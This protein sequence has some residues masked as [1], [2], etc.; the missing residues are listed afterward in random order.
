MSPVRAERGLPRFIQPIG[1]MNSA[2]VRLNATSRSI[3][4][5][6]SSLAGCL[7]FFMGSVLATAID[8]TRTEDTVLTRIAFGSCADQH[9]PC[10][11]W[12]TI[13]EYQPGLLLLLGDTV[14]ADILDGR[15]TPATPSRIQQ[16]YD[17]LARDPGFARLRERVPMLGTW[18]DHDFGNNDAGFEWEHK[19]ASARI[20]HDFFGT[21]SDSP[22]RQQAGIYQSRIFGPIGQRVQVIM[23]DTRYFRSSLTKS[24]ERLP[25]FTAFPYQ[26]QTGPGATVLGNTQ[27][28]WLEQQLG[29]PA[30][31]RL[32]ASS[33]QV[34]SNEHPFEKWGNFPEE[35]TRLFELIRKTGASGLLILSGDRHLGDISVC[36]QSIDYPLY[37]ITASG[38]NQARQSWRV[39][40]PNAYRVAGL[41]YGNHFGAIEIDWSQKPPRLK[42]Q[43][44]HE[45]G[46]IAVQ[47]QIDLDKLQAPLPPAAIPAGVL[48]PQGALQAEIS[49]PVT[50][51][52]RVLSG[53]EIGNMERIYLNSEKDF[54]NSGNFAVVMMGQALKDRW[55]GAGLRSFLNRTIQVSGKISLSNQRKQLIVSEPDQIRIVPEEKN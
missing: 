9:R 8:E 31:I 30:E 19:A 15:L 40:E 27:W 45:D 47:A 37:D 5:L 53:R 41:P 46:E 22:L 34:L 1:P 6:L 39:N 33:I 42:L 32:L 50:V 23:L 35:R 36:E 20:F 28:D 43:L 13:D 4:A 17:Q 26:P 24:R 44:R 49:E 11:I 12:Q 25:G 38:F 51:Q 54:Q 48:D 16:A 52:F 29:K 2:L 21:P 10:P 55:E 7:I 3:P 18:D 14:Y